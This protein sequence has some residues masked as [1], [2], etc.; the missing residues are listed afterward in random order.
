MEE[1]VREGSKIKYNKIWQ[2]FLVGLAI[3]AGAILINSI[4]NYFSIST[5]YSFASSINEAGFFQ[6]F[7]NEGFDLIWLFL[8]YPLL[9]GLIGYYMTNY[10][11]RYCQ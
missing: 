9:L 6:A 10:M 4:A 3:L 5:W 2:I 11:S 8:I 1:N 7:K